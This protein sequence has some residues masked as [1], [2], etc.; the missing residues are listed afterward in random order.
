MAQH[1]NNY[2]KLHNST[3][4]GVV[5]KGSA[6]AEPVI[7]LDTLLELT[8]NAEVDGVKYDGVDLWLADPHIS[9]ESANDDVKRIAD[10]IASYG[11]KVGSFV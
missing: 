5:G 11:L 2:P 4:P 6:G 7:P 10:H 1:A 8:A 9:I 3:W